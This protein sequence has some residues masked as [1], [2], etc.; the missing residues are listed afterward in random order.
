MWEAADVSSTGTLD[1]CG[2]MHGERPCAF[3]DALHAVADLHTHCRRPCM[4]CTAHAV[5]MR[6]CVFACA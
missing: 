5:M 3:V 2:R 4:H 6:A 1:T